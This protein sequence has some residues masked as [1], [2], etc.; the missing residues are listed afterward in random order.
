MS[1]IKFIVFA[2]RKRTVGLS[3]DHFNLFIK[4]FILIF[5]KDVLNKSY[6]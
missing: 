3:F 6:K 5:S 1:N 2:P 4:K